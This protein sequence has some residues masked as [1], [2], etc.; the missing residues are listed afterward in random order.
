MRLPIRLIFFIVLMVCTITIVS[1]FSGDNAALNKPAVDAFGSRAA[2]NA[3]VDELLE[4]SN[5]VTEKT[6]TKA[7]D[8]LTLDSRGR[9]A[10]T[11][12]PTPAAIPVL[13]RKITENLGE[14]WKTEDAPPTALVVT[15]DGALIYPARGA[16]WRQSTPGEESEVFKSDATSLSLDATG[17]KLLLQHQGGLIILSGP[18]F[19]QVQKID[20]PPVGRPMWGLKENELLFVEEKINFSATEKYRIRL[21]SVA[22]DYQTG[23]TSIPGWN[24]E[25]RYSTIGTLPAAG[26]LWAHLIQYY[27]ID[28]TPAS[29]YLLDDDGMPIAPLTNAGAAADIQPSGASTGAIAWIRTY[30]RGGVSGRAYYHSGD[31]ESI[32]GV[33]L[34]SRPTWQVALS[35]EGEFGAYCVSNEEGK[36][37]IHRFTR[38]VLP[39]KQSLFED[40][41]GADTAFRD[42]VARV[43]DQIKDAFLRENPGD[44]LQGTEW[45]GNILRS[46]PKPEQI[47]RM[48]DALETALG[49]EFG[50]VLDPGPGGLVQLDA[51]FDEAGSYIAEEPPM[52]LALASHLERRMQATSSWILDGDSNALSIDDPGFIDTD[53]ISYTALAPF[54][55]A[56]ERITSGVSLEKSWRDALQNNVGPYYLAENFRDGVREQIHAAEIKK[57][58]SA[59]LL[60]NPG[61]RLRVYR[62]IK[63]NNN[64]LNLDLLSAAKKTGDHALTLLVASRI[65]QGNPASGKALSIFAT[66]L[67]D[68]FY[69]DEATKVYHQA[70]LL[71]PL[72]VDIRFAYADCLAGANLLDDA[73]REYE[74]LKALDSTGTLKEELN[75]RFEMLQSLRAEAGK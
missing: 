33:Q 62:D 20:H 39:L 14:L 49:K 5:E 15:S 9:K 72:D 45:G 18:Q 36:Y 61:H 38:D 2:M 56:R 53:G 68:A 28:P 13:R 66:A 34:T 3:S 46:A 67:N 11:P 48:G 37:E 60:E 31:P 27:Q 6:S 52:I 42:A 50:M 17:G 63:T 40:N 70:V 44:G 71:A 65:A 23:K 58:G 54:S 64:T 57:A 75:G 59:V 7:L 29:I 43:V 22:Y 25:L 69:S 19:R 8:G 55:I 73:Q 47:D 51:F 74:I 1:C 32:A 4:Q 16:L 26:I 10:V 35:P 41:A 21:R 30:R 12:S 24:S